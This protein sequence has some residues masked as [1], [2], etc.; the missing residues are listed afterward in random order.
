MSQ[1]DG[2]P[3]EKFDPVRLRREQA[4][5]RQGFWPKLRRLAAKIPFSR[6][7]LAAY[8]CAADGDTPLYVKAVLTSALAYFVIP[9]DMI[10]DFLAGIGYT[11]DATVLATAMEA[12][13]H[14]ITP[15]HRARAEKAI[16]RLEA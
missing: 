11:D 9:A 14:H 6:D 4:R 15:G 2:N 8:Y 1:I 16:R 12:M 10:P 7:L 5:V 13:R 3:P